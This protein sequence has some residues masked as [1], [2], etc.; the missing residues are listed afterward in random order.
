MNFLIVNS[1]FKDCQT[2]TNSQKASH[3][4]HTWLLLI[5]DTH[6]CCSTA[7]VRFLICFREAQPK[8]LTSL[9]SS[10]SSG[11]RSAS[12]C[13]SAFGLSYWMASIPSRSHTHSQVRHCPV[14]DDK[15]AI[16]LFY[17]KTSS[18]RTVSA[19]LL[20]SLSWFMNNCYLNAAGHAAAAVSMWRVP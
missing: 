8:Q 2:R 17:V 4:S 14:L 13:G 18:V 19:G 5:T 7:H 20:P 15:H 10:S 6:V 11:S 1:R 9:L 16:A 12:P 3:T